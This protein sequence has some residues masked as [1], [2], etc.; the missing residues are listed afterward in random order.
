MDKGDAVLGDFNMH[1]PA[2][3]ADPVSLDQPPFFQSVGDACDG[4]VIQKHDFRQS[5][6]GDGTVFVNCPKADELRDGH[7]VVFLNVFRMFGKS[8]DDLSQTHHDLHAD[9]FGHLSAPFDCRAYTS[10]GVFFENQLETGI[11]RS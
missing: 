10:I 5:T 11:D 4:T 7:L 9:G 2:V 1:L 8:L 3:A 6:Q